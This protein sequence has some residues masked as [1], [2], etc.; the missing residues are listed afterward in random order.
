MDVGKASPFLGAMTFRISAISIMTLYITTFSIKTS[1]LT[2]LSIMTFSIVTLGVKTLS[3]RT[4][5][6]KEFFAKLSIT[7]IC[8]Y[9]K[10]C[11][12]LTGYCYAE[13]RYAE[14]HYAAF[15]YAEFRSAFSC[16]CNHLKIFALCFVRWFG[17]PFQTNGKKCVSD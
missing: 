1:K 5:N 9:A 7:N 11:I 4:L 3:I 6:I 2:I 17:G 8:H 15:G 12:Y 14:C 10:C 16:Q 13:H